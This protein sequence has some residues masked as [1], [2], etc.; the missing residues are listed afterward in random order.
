MLCRVKNKG[1][2]QVHNLDSAKRQLTRLLCKRDTQLLRE[3]QFDY[4]EDG[5]EANGPTDALKGLRVNTEGI[6]GVK[7]NRI[8]G[9][10]FP[11]EY[12]QKTTGL[13]YVHKQTKSNQLLHG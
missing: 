11:F 3:K 8:K 4:E 12:S 6:S 10:F 9:S 5:T 7:K 2:K 1:H 13:I